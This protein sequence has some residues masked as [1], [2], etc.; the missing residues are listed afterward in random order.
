MI[1]EPALVVTLFI[2]IIDQVRLEQLVHESGHAAQR[3]LADHRAPD[4]QCQLLSGLFICDILGRPW[5]QGPR[6]LLCGIGRALRHVVPGSDCACLAA[7]GRPSCVRLD[8]RLVS[9]ITRLS[10]FMHR[11]IL[12]SLLLACC[13]VSCISRI[14]RVDEC[15]QLFDARVVL[16]PLPLAWGCSTSRRPSTT[17]GT[18]MWRVAA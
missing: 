17:R 16:P 4:A 11:I 18:L 5:S 7:C 9:A 3:L 12:E 6:R 10:R 14:K 13:M 15:I 1:V 8:W 2:V